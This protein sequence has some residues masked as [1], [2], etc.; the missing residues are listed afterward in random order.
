M[1]GILLRSGELHG[2]DQRRGNR[3]K[4]EVPIWHRKKT[5][6]RKKVC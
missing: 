4:M 5:L 1:R 2:R 3:R 6:A